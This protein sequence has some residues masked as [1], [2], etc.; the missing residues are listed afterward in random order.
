MERAENDRCRHFAAIVRRKEIVPRCILSREEAEQRIVLP[1]SGELG[2]GR[3]RFP[4]VAV[5]V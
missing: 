3:P 4:K 2:V 5:S 1:R